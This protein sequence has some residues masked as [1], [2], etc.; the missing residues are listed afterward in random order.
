[1]KIALTAAGLV[2]PLDYVSRPLLLVEDGVILEVSSI[3]ETALPSNIKHYDFGD[4]TLAPGFLDIHVHGGSGHDVMNDDAALLAGMEQFMAKHGVTSYLPTTVTAS[5]DLTFRSLERLGNA[6]EKA[7]T[8]TST[9]PGRDPIRAQPLG[10]HLEGPFINPKRCGVHEVEHLLSPT[11]AT[12]DGMCEAAKNR[13]SMITIAPELPGSEEVIR[14]A[15][16]RGICVSIGHSDAGTGAAYAAL[17]WG[18]SHATHTFNAMPGLHHRDPGLLG[19]VLSDD[20]LSADIIADRLHV[21]PEIVRLFLKAKGMNR[22]VLISDAMSGTG[23]PDGK[24]RLGSMEVDVRAQQCRRNGKLAGSVLTLDV[25]IQNVMQIASL[26]L[27]SA[28]RL[29]TINPALTIGVAD[30]KGLL[31]PGREADIVVLTAQGQVTK[32]MIGGRMT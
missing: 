7:E 16:S 19:V 13:V 17:D 1:M 25:A 3:E 2:T 22:S 12:F 23:M 4:A 9:I 30:R 8:N 26:D 15:Q 18:A 21:A 20:R 27:Q 11:L 10:I 6:L 28:V 31:A 29:V 32:T 24:Y 5:L 14:R